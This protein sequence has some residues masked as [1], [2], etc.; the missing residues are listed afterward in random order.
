MTATPEAVGGEARELLAG[1]LAAE[2]LAAL[3]E[4]RRRG[5]PADPRPLYRLLGAR[6]LL[7]VS[8]P[9]ACGG[10]GLHPRCGA[11]VVA[12][13]AAG[14]LGLAPDEGPPRA[15]VQPFGRLWTMAGVDVTFGLA[16]DPLAAIMGIA[17]TVVGAAI[18]VAA[19]GA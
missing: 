11:A 4:A 17:V 12:L 7:A 2:A 9:E 18:A 14:A 8:W 5:E 3:A 16:L 6:R 10:R 15:L 13:V 19:A 1:P